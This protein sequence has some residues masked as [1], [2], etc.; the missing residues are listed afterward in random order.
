[1][2]TKTQFIAIAFLLLLSGYAFGQGG[3]LGN[4]RTAGALPLGWTGGTTPGSLEI[5]N[6]FAGQ[7]INFFA[8]GPQRMTI[9]G[10]TGFVGTPI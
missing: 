2:K 4:F 9:L 6:N 1:M 10:T 7:P 3:A 8:G 5:R